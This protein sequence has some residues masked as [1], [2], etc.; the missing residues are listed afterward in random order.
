M[1]NAG[2]SRAICSIKGQFIEMSKDHRPSN[3]DELPRI[4]NAGGYI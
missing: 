2:D 3:P 1:A 4:K